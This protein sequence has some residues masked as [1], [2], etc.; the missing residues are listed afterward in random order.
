MRFNVLFQKCEDRTSGFSQMCQNFEVPTKDVFSVRHEP[1]KK[2]EK[3]TFWESMKNL[4]SFNALL[5]N[6]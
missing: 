5:E 1:N 3:I 4:D 6:A 2:Y